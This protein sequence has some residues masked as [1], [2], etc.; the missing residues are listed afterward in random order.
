MW[1]ILYHNNHIEQIATFRVTVTGHHYTHRLHSNAKGVLGGFLGCSV[2]ISVNSSA[3]NPAL[4][5]G[6][7]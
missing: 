7:L 1:D 3:V 2:N 4:I 5:E 6:T